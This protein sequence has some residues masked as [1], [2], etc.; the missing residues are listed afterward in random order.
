M[1]PEKLD[2]FFRAKKRSVP[3]ILLTTPDSRQTTAEITEFLSKQE[4]K[5][6]GE[7]SPVIAVHWDV[8]QG[9]HTPPIGE[10]S[11]AADKLGAEWLKSL[12][13]PEEDDDQFKA[14][15]G[16][17]T[18]PTA[19]PGEGSIVAAL[20]IIR[21][22]P[23]QVIVFIHGTDRWLNEEPDAR[24]AIQAAANLRNPFKASARMLVF[25]TSQTNYQLP[26]ELRKDT[27]PV[28]EPLP[29][30]KE[31]ER[32]F[33]KHKSIG[34][35]VTNK[36]TRRKAASFL[37]GF[38][39]FGAEQALYL[40]FTSGQGIDLKELR[41]L[42]WSMWDS[43]P[44]LSVRHCKY[45]QDDVASHAWLKQE[46]LELMEGDEDEAPRVIMHVGEIEKAMSNTEHD[47]TNIKQDALGQWLD[48][49]ERN[50]DEG[51]VL[52][53]P[54]G[55]SKTFLAE[56]I[57]PTVDLDTLDF[58][59]NGG[60][61]ASGGLSGIAEASIREALATTRP[62]GRRFWIA[63][64]N[65]AHD[66]DIALLRRF[67]WG[68]IFCDLPDER[69]RKQIWKLQMKAHGLKGSLKG[70]D[71]NLWSGAEIRNC[72]RKAKRRK[73]TIAEV[74]PTINPVAIA[75]PKRIHNVRKKAH[76]TYKCSITGKPYVYDKLAQIEK[77]HQLRAATVAEGDGR[78]LAE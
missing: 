56:T 58:D 51:I 20:N 64:C 5:L 47:T 43:T 53:G 78:L 45:T 23:I 22:A 57:G 6:N 28:E 8:D 69:E 62:L 29:G 65:E 9:L 42:R 32:L 75:D 15:A 13:P 68:I 37:T 12:A 41:S 55:C 39:T 40:S 54:P 77:Q 74:A 49:M 18:S 66:L 72:C 24:V 7:D 63:T 59:I 3:F 14:I 25:C 52:V 48:D 11:P 46:L 61:A 36:V 17:D 38:S 1:D 60:K 26:H 31:L 70:I 19:A 34:N 16:E 76:N 44:G 4:I 2:Q 67:T 50:G 10:K 33:D 73:K 27:I 35:E 21:T 71:D 30:P